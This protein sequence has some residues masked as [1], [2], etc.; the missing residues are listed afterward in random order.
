MLTEEQIKIRIAKRAAAELSDGMIV[1]LGVGIPTLVANYIGNKKVYLQSENGLMGVG[2]Y[3]DVETEDPNLI[4]AGR[5]RVSLISGG[6][7]F[8]SAEAFAQIRGSHIDCTI[9][10]GLQVSQSG[11]LANWLVPGK[12]VLGVGGAMDLV[13]GVPKV[14]VATQHI[15]K[16]G[17]AK[18]V[19]VCTLPLTAEGVVSMVITEYVV[20]RIEDGQMILE[21]ITND[22]T[23]AQIQEITT[24]DYRIGKDFIVRE[25]E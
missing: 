24:A 13:V 8:D 14:I 17:G 2:P 21:E 1:N 22:I 18:I 12:A 9:I 11:D 20:F 10:G 6:S 3:P 25:V 7:Y 16:K 15:T 5:K 4:N 23:L 19:P